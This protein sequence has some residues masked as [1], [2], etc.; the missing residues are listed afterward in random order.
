MVLLAVACG[1]GTDS[2]EGSSST[3]TQPEGISGSDVVA[4]IESFGANLS[5]GDLDEASAVWA[6]SWSSIGIPMSS[7]NA[8]ITP[9]ASVLDALTFLQAWTAL[10][11]SN[12][13]AENEQ[14]AVITVR[15]TATV[16]GPF[17]EALELEPFELPFRFVAT[18]DGLVAVSTDFETI[19]GTTNTWPPEG[20]FYTYEAFYLYAAQDA[21]FATQHQSGVGQPLPSLDSAS[22]HVDLAE[23]WINEGRP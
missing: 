23:H 13:S 18:A 12:C 17:P 16:S 5:S 4:W 20:A 7:G 22:A 6:E 1:S 10:G 8:A 21:G 3:P 9:P 19:Q 2:I 15:C 11:F 14:G